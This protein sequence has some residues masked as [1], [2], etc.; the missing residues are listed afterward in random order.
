LGTPEE[1]HA[2]TKNEKGVKMDGKRRF[3]IM[4]AVLSVLCIFLGIASS[5]AFAKE[6]YL[7]IAS[8][9]FAASSELGVLF[10]HRSKVFDVVIKTIGEIGSAIDDYRDYIRTEKPSYVLLVGKYGDFPVFKIRLDGDT[11]ESYNYYTASSITGHP[12]Q[13]I[14]LGLFL[15]NDRTELANIINKTI[16]TE[17]SLPMLPMAVYAHAGSIAPL[18]PLPTSFCEEMLIEMNDLFFKK[19]GYSFTLAKA[20]DDMENPN[21]SSID[22]QM[23]NNG[24]RFVLYHGHGMI[25]S[26]A[27]GM[28]VSNIPSLK[29]TFYPLIFSASCLTG[30]FSGNVEGHTKE[31]FARE[32]TA[33]AHGPSAFIG[34]YHKSGRGQNLFLNG[35]FK[36]VFE[37]N[38]RRMGDAFIYGLQ[39]LDTPATVLKYI[40]GVTEN[41]RI[42]CAWQFHYF[43]DPALQLMSDSTVLVHEPGWNTYKNNFSVTSCALSTQVV[44]QWFQSQFCQTKIGLYNVLGKLVSERN[45]IYGAGEHMVIL[46]CESLANGMYY[47]KLSTFTASAPLVR[48]V[49]I[50]H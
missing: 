20:D 19:A 24:V 12:N 40:D 29:N 42:R 46:P 32:I 6:T 17:S 36:G 16:T 9:S 43:G 13:D 30:S 11:I 5:T 1:H 50:I 38:I 2:K 35:M 18:G 34:A 8:D 4:R 7:I 3:P 47:V 26:W 37:Q 45:A 39:S 23:I 31:C 28:G 21:D 41:E 10:A 27:F 25:D 22:I 48:S 49:M 15:V 14:P 33:S 44:I